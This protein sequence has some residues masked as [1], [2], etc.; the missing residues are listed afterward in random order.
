VGRQSVHSRPV[1]DGSPERRSS[2]DRP[3]EV[4]GG[5]SLSWTSWPMLRS[6][7]RAVLAVLFIAIMAWTIQS[8]FRTTYFTVV[9]VLLVWGQVAGFFLPTRYELTEE[10]LTVRGLLGRREKD[11]RDF[12]SY[13]VDPDGLL[14]SPFVGRSRLE[15]FRGVSLQFHGNRDEVVAFVERH[16]ERESTDD[17]VGDEG[18]SERAPAS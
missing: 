12:R 13:Y 11:W 15:R 1:E 18:Q 2:E 14:L 16:M 5:E 10:R 7:V 3:E 17:R 6:P 4:G 8:V 9:A